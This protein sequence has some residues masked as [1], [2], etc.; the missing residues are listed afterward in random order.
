MSVCK[1]TQERLVQEGLLLLTGKCPVEG[2][3]QPVAF[4]DREVGKD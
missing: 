1:V 3:G 4:H 2:C